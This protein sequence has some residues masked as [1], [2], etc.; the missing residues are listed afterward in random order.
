MF[1]KFAKNHRLR[2]TESV[3][4]GSCQKGKYRIKD[5]ID[6]ADADNHN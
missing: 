3:M 1:C 4:I 5:H 6:D 2:V